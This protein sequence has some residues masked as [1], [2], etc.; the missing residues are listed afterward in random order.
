MQ[1][2]ARNNQESYSGALQIVQ[3]SFYVDN[4]LAS[5][6]TTSEAKLTVDKL[7]SMLATGGFDLRQWASNQSSVISHLPT[8]AR[9]S[10]AEQWLEQ[11][12]TDPM[13][14]TLSLRWNCDA[15]TLGYQYR[16]IENATLTMRTAYQV[17]ATQYDPLGFIVPFT[18][19][20]KVL[21]QQLWYKRR[22][23][24]NPN[25]PQ[26][27]HAA[28]DTWES[29]LK[30]LSTIAIPRCYSST[31]NDVR[32]KYDLHVFC[33]PSERAYGAVA[34]LIEY[35]QDATFI[36]A[37]SRVA[38]RRQQSMP[39]LELCAALAVAQLA[40]LLKD[41][42]TLTIQQT[43]LS[44]SCRFKVFVRTQVSEI[45]ELTEHSTWRYVDTQQ[46]PADD[47]TRGKPLS[48]FTVPGRWSQ[49]P[50]FLKLSSVHWPKRPEPARSEE[51]PELKGVTI[52]CL[53]TVAPDYT[54]PDASQVTDNS[55][56]TQLIDPREAELILL[57]K[58]QA[59]SFPEETTAL[60]THKPIPN[61]SRLI[62]LA[63]E[64]DPVT[65]VIRVGGDYGDWKAQML[66]KF[67]LSC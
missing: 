26:D 61:H 58:C 4:Y 31:P 45:Q 55:A 3:Q 2:H 21:I 49:G 53:T 46:N 38:P 14:P 65:N 36:M 57:R 43:V 56:N 48:S 33:D 66:N 62:H 51:L 8:E 59:Q 17:L 42:I 37:R 39:H 54:V 10:A 29:E 41:E 63:P 6:P 9:S 64:W 30:Y 16:P 25:L 15:N 20:T 22:D 5:F 27:L 18:T 44:D 34:Y 35:T 47:I 24:D 11:N 50:S 60:K 67:T 32:W 40:K 13:E 19:R 28:W 12:R 52:C 1:Q 23:W 7:H